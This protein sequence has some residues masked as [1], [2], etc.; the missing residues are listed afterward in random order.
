MS[1]PSLFERVPI[2]LPAE[3][4]ACNRCLHRY[5]QDPSR[6]VQACESYKRDGRIYWLG[7]CADCWDREWS[8]RHRKRVQKALER[9]DA[10]LVVQL[11]DE[12]VKRLARG[13]RFYE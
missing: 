8:E 7:L 6:A 9:G 13:R 11:A 3:G 10:E 5:D 2:A 4:P 1:E 12:K